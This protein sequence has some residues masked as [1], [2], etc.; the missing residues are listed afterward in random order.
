ML[1]QHDH[2]RLTQL[3]KQ[4]DLG[5]REATGNARHA[6]MF[7][8]VCMLDTRFVRGVLR[9]EGYAKRL[10]VPVEEYAWRACKAIM[11]G[12]GGRLDALAVLNARTFNL[13]QSVDGS[14]LFTGKEREHMETHANVQ[15]LS[16]H[17]EFTLAIRCVH[18]VY[19]L[20]VR[21]AGHPPRLLD[22]LLAMRDD[23]GP[24]LLYDYLPMRKLWTR[25]Q[26][27]LCMPQELGVTRTAYNA[28]KRSCRNQHLQSDPDVAWWCTLCNDLSELNGVIF[29][30]KR[31]A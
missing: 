11:S 5:I 30:Q 14:A 4:I 12:T 15:A 6:T 13:A 21:N 23:L 18:T 1:T 22:V 27:V 24:L 16:A 19:D 28:F 31:S 25:C 10:R 7:R 17:K 26:D 3:A 8:R 9:V 20:H 29:A 2:L